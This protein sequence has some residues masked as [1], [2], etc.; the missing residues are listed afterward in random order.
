MLRM[1][2]AGLCHSDLS[3]IDGSRPR[4]MPMVLG[5][6]ACGEVVEI[7]ADVGRAARGRSGSCSRSC[8]AAAPALRAPA[9]GLHSAS[10]GA[11]ANVAG[12]LLGCETLAPKRRRGTAPSPRRLRIR[13]AYGR[14]AGSV[15]CVDR[16]LDPAIAA[17]FGCAVMTGVGAVVNTA[18]VAAGDSVAVFGV[19]G[20]GPRGAAR[21]AAVGAH[22][23]IA[24]DTL[25]GQ[26]RDRSS[27]R[28]DARRACISGSGHGERGAR[29]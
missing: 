25:A 20:V 28:R 7:G 29:R 17:L 4:V 18:R 9:A 21:A 14:V 2:A 22:P 15:V 8:R 19:G 16:E 6:E 5:H 12:T 3:V 23:L 26:A 11:H 1:L 10:S 27:L 24:V 13:G